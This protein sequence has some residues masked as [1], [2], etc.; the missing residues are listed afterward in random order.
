MNLKNVSRWLIVFGVAACGFGFAAETPN[1]VGPLPAQ[2][3]YAV[4]PGE[5]AVAAFQILHP[6][7]GEAQ[8]AARL[9]VWDMSGRLV[10]TLDQTATLPAKGEATVLFKPAIPDTGYYDARCE[11]RIGDTA[12]SPVS[13]SFVR[14]RQAGPREGESRFGM[15]SA[16]DWYTLEDRK[17]LGYYRYFAKTGSPWTTTDM[18]W[19]EAQPKKKGPYDWSHFDTRFADSKAAGLNMLPHLFGI[20]L[21][22]TSHKDYK[23]GD[24]SSEYDAQ[25]YAP[26]EEYWEDWGAFVYAF[27]DRYK[28]DLTYL[29][30]WNEFDTAYWRGT[31]PEFA[32][33]LKIAYEQ[34][35]RAK[36]DIKIVIDIS[37]ARIP[38]YQ[39]LWQAGGGDYCDI[40]SIHN[41]QLDKLLP[42]EET[43]SF[44]EYRAFVEWRDKTCPGKPV[45]DSEI[46]W[47]SEPWSTPD[48]Y[49]HGEAAHAQYTVRGLLLGFMAGMEK[50]IYFPYHSW[51][52][53]R[54]GLSYSHGGGLVRHDL[55]PRPAFASYYTMV[56]MLADATFVRRLDAGSDTAYLAEFKRGNGF[57]TVAWSTDEAGEWATLSTPQAEV[58][59][60]AMLGQDEK[61]VTRNGLLGIPLTG[62]PVYLKSA[63]PFGVACDKALL[64]GLEASWTIGA[65]D[66]SSA[67]RSAALTLAQT[68]ARSKHAYVSLEYAGASAAAFEKRMDAFQGRPA[69]AEGEI[70]LPRSA[71]S[72]FVQAHWRVQE[73]GCPPV[74]VPVR[75]PVEAVNQPVWQA[76]SGEDTTGMSQ[77]LAAPASAQGVF[78]SLP[79][80]R[81]FDMSCKGRN[82]EETF[83]IAEQKGV[84]DVV[85]LPINRELQQVEVTFS[86]LLVEPSFESTAKL[87]FPQQGKAQLVW[88]DGSVRDYMTI[89]GKTAHSGAK[90]IEMAG[91]GAGRTR[92][93][94]EITNVQQFI[95]IKPDTWYSVSTWM[96]MPKTEDGQGCLFVISDSKEKGVLMPHTYSVLPGVGEE[97]RYVHATVRTEPWQNF[98]RISVSLHGNGLMYV[99]DVMCIEGKLPTDVP[100]VLDMAVVDAQGKWIALQPQTKQE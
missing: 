62:S 72:G 10:E 5:Q 25:L 81:A 12:L 99:D 77:A 85:W 98:L 59:S 53:E 24:R 26:E 52:M 87:A 75:I 82:G 6:G 47:L 93:T 74:R 44:D 14:L 73:E 41:Y 38:V 23:K 28:D 17:P 15:Y 71:D 69:Q 43:S 65:A 95:P 94:D 22:A 79:K 96:K 89:T 60:V 63:E 78:I 21:W 29:R 84:S 33:L 2:A 16:G 97:W 88:E 39:A 7:E 40:I 4:F 9:Y 54:E 3:N 58:D 20:P 64:H 55:D 36:P 92:H 51:F 68:D 31:I 46:C 13:I 67:A 66:A 57:V 32:R 42:P 18:W 90:S 48:W 30:I 76:A 1:S 91:L 50:M 27:V 49:G 86:Q 45:W 11:V 100:R 35:H 8:A 80:H 34:A 37:M 61:L 19:G 56:D 70:W 83:T